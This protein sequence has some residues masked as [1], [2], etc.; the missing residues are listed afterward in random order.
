[1]DQNILNIISFHYIRK[2]TIFQY[3]LPNYLLLES[4]TLGT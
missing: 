4:E 1:M 3:S 2:Y